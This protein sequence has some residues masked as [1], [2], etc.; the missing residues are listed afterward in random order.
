MIE[1]W[2]SWGWPAY[3]ILLAAVWVVAT[4]ILSVA[5]GW[6][7]LAEVYPAPRP[8][9]GKPMRF[10]SAQLRWGTNYNG[11]LDFV[12]DVDGLHVSILLPFRLGHPP[13]FFPWSEITYEERPS[14][15]L[16]SVELRFARAPQLT[17]TIPKGLAERLLQERT[18]HA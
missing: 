5:G 17:M 16:S 7:Q 6:R 14:R 11:C 15:L 13:L 18:R 8:P 9:I 10:Q 4:Q 3:P 1:S 12:A 2:E